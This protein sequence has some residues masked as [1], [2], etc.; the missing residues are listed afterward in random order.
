MTTQ[1]R[2][3]AHTAF[4]ARRAFVAALR[5]KHGFAAD[6]VALEG[7]NVTA[8]FDELAAYDAAAEA[9]PVAEVIDIEAEARL[10]WAALPTSVKLACGDTSV[11]VVAP[12]VTTKAMARAT[13]QGDIAQA[14]AVANHNRVVLASLIVK[15]AAQPHDHARIDFE[16]AAIDIMHH[17]HAALTG[18][19]IHA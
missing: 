14:E 9:A 19:D 6:D 3:A 12:C 1:A 18:R 10:Q 2:T 4:T 13:I 5:V 17:A 7:G 8:F 16:A 11:A 15:G